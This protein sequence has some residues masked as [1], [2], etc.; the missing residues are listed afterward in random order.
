MAMAFLCNWAW[1]FPVSPT[2]AVA[3]GALIFGAS[4]L[5]DLT[6]SCMKRDA[7]IKDAGGLIPGHGG[8]LDRFDS[9]FFTAPMAYFCWYMHI[10]GRKY[11]SQLV[12]A[13]W[14]GWAGGL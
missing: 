12:G 10:H 7:G 11:L 4:L 2:A 9:Y 6:V 8:F 13:A 5:G 14:A 3:A 1:G